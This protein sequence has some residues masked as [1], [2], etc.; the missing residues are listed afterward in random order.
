MRSEGDEGHKFREISV[1]YAT[2]RGILN[3]TGTYGEDAKLEAIHEFRQIA[4]G[5]QFQPNIA[6]RITRKDLFFT[7]NSDGV[8]EFRLVL[9]LVALIIF[10]IVVRRT[11][12][13]S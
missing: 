5:V 8:S 11:K 10:W 2:E 12:Y 9:F 4:K 6:Y 13:S 7:V 3:L 1:S